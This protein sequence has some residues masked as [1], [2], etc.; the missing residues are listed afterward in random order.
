[1][2]SPERS[3]Q[4]LL[5]MPHSIVQR[6]DVKDLQSAG[7]NK[8]SDQSLAEFRKTA[9]FVATLPWQLLEA[10]H[11]LETLCEENENNVP[12]LAKPITVLK[13]EPWLPE[14]GPDQREEEAIP[15]PRRVEVTEPTP[16]ERRARALKQPAAAAF[17]RPA[18]KR[19]SA[20]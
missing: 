8:F 9:R 11:Y 20:R 2:S 13:R 4:P 18:L 5:V 14:P 6:L 19:P 10:Q 1:M 17:Q 7:R 3:Q 12:R 15:D 16:V